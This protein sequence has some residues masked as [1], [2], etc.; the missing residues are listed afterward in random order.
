MFGTGV[1]LLLQWW[2]IATNK[3][4]LVVECILT[5]LIAEREVKIQI[6]TAAKQ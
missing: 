1:L 6:C 3:D 5:G 2:L 4:N